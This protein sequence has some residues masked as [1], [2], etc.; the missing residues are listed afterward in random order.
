MLKFGD[1]FFETT[2]SGL[3]AASPAGWLPAYFSVTV[4]ETSRMT[5]R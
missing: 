4:I 2:G 1:I 5:R 3:D